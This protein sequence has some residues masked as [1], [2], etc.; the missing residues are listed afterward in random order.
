MVTKMAVQLLSL[1]KVYDGTEITQDYARQREIACVFLLQVSS[2]FL[3]DVR[4]RQNEPSFFRLRQR[5]T[6]DVCGVFY[7]ASKTP[8]LACRDLRCAAGFR[9]LPSICTINTVKKM[10]SSVREP[11]PAS[12]TESS[13]LCCQFVHF[14]PVLFLLPSC[15]RSRPERTRQDCPRLLWQTAGTSGR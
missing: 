5:H 14:V 9:Q 15:R 4:L 11:N 8:A 7:L 2:S 1:N 3:G 12:T 13:F 10:Y 6:M